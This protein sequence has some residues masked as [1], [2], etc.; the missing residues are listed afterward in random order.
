M[1]SLYFILLFTTLPFIINAQ[2]KTPAD[3][4]GYELGERFTRHHQM[5][6]YFNY[7]SS[8]RPNVKIEQYGTTWEH[9]PLF[10]AVLTS[11]EDS[12]HLEDIRTNNLKMTGLTEGA[13]VGKKKAIVW[14]SYNVHGNESVSMEAAMQTLFELS[15]P[16]NAK[17]QEWLKNTVVILDPCINPDGRERYA[18]FYYQ[19]G[20]K[21]PNSNLDSKEHHEPWPG[22]RANHYLFDLN[23]D[24][25]W[26]KQTES[27]QRLEKYQ[28]WM[29][30]VH[31]DFHEQGINSPYYFAPAAKPFHELITPWQQ[32]LQTMIGKNNAAYFDKE[33]WLYFTK[34]VFDLLYP[35]YGDTYPTY[36]GAIGMT[37]EQGG[38]GRAGLTVETE[39]G[40]ELTLKD[41]IAHHHTNGLSTV[42]VT[43]K[44][45]ERVISEFEKYFR[46]APGKARYKSYLIKGDNPKDKLNLL[47]SFLEAHKI[48]FGHPQTGKKTVNGFNFN[49]GNS[50]T[51]T[52]SSNDLIVNVYQPKSTLVSVLFEPKTQLEDSMTYDITAWS[53]PWVYGLEAFALNERIDVAGSYDKKK[54]E[55]NQQSID[56][57]YA[58]VFRYASFQDAQYLAFL[59]Q[60]GL[61]LRS[62]EQAFTVSGKNFPAGSVIITRRNNENLEDLDNLVVES[63][64]KYGREL[65]PTSTGFVDSGLDFGSN[66]VNYIKTPQIAVLSGA[67]T[68]SLS[69]GEI[70]YFFEQELEYPV[71][72]LDTDYFND[73]DLSSYDVLVLPPG[74]YTLFNEDVLGR[75]STWVS[76][77]GRLIAIGNALNSFVKKDG[78][79]LKNYA[80]DEEKKTVDKEKEDLKNKLLRYEERAR[81]DISEEIIGAI[82]AVKMDNS[83]P[84]AY[85]YDHRYYSLKTSSDRYA[86]LSEGWNVGV[87][88]KEAKPVSG[89]AGFKARKQVSET[90]VFG[91]YPK[92]EGNVVYM[93][94]NPLFRAFWENGKLL[95]SN[96]LFMV[97]Q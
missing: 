12:D 50:Q 71:T 77:G 35:S 27:R 49:T 1:R 80:T 56:K 15:D 66:R 25:A 21:I 70:W 3:Y 4:L 45:A 13:P 91:V 44:N 29:P 75:L 81:N 24:W 74:N 37:Y 14:L 95:M 97:G 90:L 64:K 72:I 87:L 86:Y 48:D 10:I 85:G 22:G 79:G 60:S 94:D 58:W 7:I 40:D 68:S 2:T 69:F 39:F 9:R 57:P 34:E 83:H 5:V 76:E 96:A 23:R 51:T 41:R 53:L 52:I 32:E 19:Y 89:F 92:G 62:S 11:P 65:T 30:H 16:N 18:N 33:G 38:S 88:P 84:L 43:S 26:L 46:D 82:Y 59:Q 63:A 28:Q 20:N 31:V 36:N 55:Q 47:A 17:T 6:E 8:V 73:I 61:K 67:Q 93:V 54:A 78:W 42:E